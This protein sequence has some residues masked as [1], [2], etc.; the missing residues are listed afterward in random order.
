MCLQKCRRTYHSIRKQALRGLREKE[1]MKKFAI[2]LLIAVLVPTCIFAANRGIFDF[3]VGAT[4]STSYSIDDIESG[5]IKEFTIDSVRFGA[6]VETK[7][8]FLSIDGKIFYDQANKGISGLVSANIAADIFFVR[9][10]AGLGYE[11][12]YNFD[13]KTFYFGNALNGGYATEFSEFKKANFD[14]NVGVD[15]LLGPVT[16]GAYATLPTATSIENGQWKE[17]FTAI[18]ENWK[19]A[20]LGAVVGF[21]LF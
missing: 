4:A 21:A 18:G 11:Y 8:A 5:A 13:S 19:Y 14:V 10:K 7:L 17:L 6:D 3:T 12:T 1:K 15:F 16:V 2:A 9:I 20:K